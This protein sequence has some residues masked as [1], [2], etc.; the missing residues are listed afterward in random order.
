MIP[1]KEKETK[2]LGQ[3]RD[4]YHLVLFPFSFYG[5]TR[6]LIE[7]YLKGKNL[8]S[9]VYLT[10]HTGKIVDFK[11]ELF[12]TLKAPVPP[13][14]FTLRS[15][16]KKL[17]EEH[18]SKRLI[19]SVEKYIRLVRLVSRCSPDIPGFSLLG[20]VTA[21]SQFIREIKVHSSVSQLDWIFSRVAS[22]PWK[23][24]ESKKKAMVAVKIFSAYQNE[25]EKENL[26]DQ[27]DIYRQATSYVKHLPYSHF[28]VEGVYEI[29][30]YQ[31][32]FLAALFTHIPSGVF[33]FVDGTSA[34]I[35]VRTLILSQTLKT[36]QQFRTWQE[37]SFSSPP[38]N[39][40][41]ICWQFP[42]VE[43]EVKGI[44][45]MIK[46]FLE[47]H[48]ESRLED[49]LV[50]FPEMLA[51]RA[52]VKRLF[53]RYQIPCE[54]VPG[55]ALTEEPAINSLLDVFHFL[56]TWS[57]E[58]LMSIL[59]SPFFHRFQHQQVEIFST[60]SRL[61]HESSGYFRDDFLKEE[62]IY[63]DLLRK[64]LQ[65]M[66]GAERKSLTQWCRYLENIISRLKW[67]SGDE[68]VNFL[69]QEF[70]LQ[71][72]SS[73]RLTRKEFVNFFRHALSLMEVEQGRG[74][75]VKVSGVLETAGLERHLCII[76]GATDQS[77]PL[78]ASK[79]DI[80]LPDRLKEELKLDTYPL[81]LARERLDLH[82]L[83]QQNRKVCFTYSSLSQGR[84]Q[85]K[86]IL[87]G[88]YREK[89]WPGQPFRFSSDPI[90]TPD[91]SWEE[92]G[93][94][95]SRD[96]RW[97]IS[98]NGLEQILCCPYR[99]FLEKIA[100][101]IPYRAPVVEEVPRFWGEIV[102]KVLEE[103]GQKQLGRIIEAGAVTEYSEYFRTRLNQ[104]LISAGEEKK[105]C[106]P[107][108]RTI[109]QERLP[110]VV[111][112]LGEILLQ[113]VGRKVVSVEEKFE[114]KTNSWI[115]TGKTDRIEQI[116]DEELEVIDFKTGTTKP[117][118]YTEHDF[119]TRHHLQLP[120]YIWALEKLTNKVYHGSIWQL[121]YQED[122]GRGEKKYPRKGMLSYLERMED[123]LEDIAS[124]LKSG[125]FPAG[126]DNRQICQMCSHF[127]YCRHAS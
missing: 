39:E 7:T 64:L 46:Q 81:R 10:A 99:F 121:S 122:S 44:I 57:W 54:I 103:I 95:L 69:F 117:P 14:T 75:G 25:L 67:N 11:T 56:E 76:G 42:S 74:Y 115:I 127:A 17:V 3:N 119:T 84:P 60:C 111:S 77:L 107:L 59:T 28:L 101:L 26:L 37:K 52:L 113:H 86:S 36:L 73:H 93:K 32:E 16:A 109:L 47:E 65:P 68:Q 87:I 2:L 116:S 66:S 53:A 80:F 24:E 34:P 50:A 110:L 90:F 91:F 124:Q 105:V 102:H 61:R 125:Q 72:K 23:Y 70:L 123:Y 88:S 98:V 31:Q 15:L 30:A 49:C 71:V 29:P 38:S 19:S 55:V 9:L 33:A 94:F 20:M 114:V 58:A 40:N 89:V 48:P 83:T 35:D 118:S 108:I 45:T 92:I 106:S 126:P 104:L 1:H 78:S 8:Q 112:K 12:L 5:K 27:E 63:F 41:I 4:D 21:I 13:D 85:M 62:G 6:Y 18:S 79:M 22:Y 43:E 97:Q 82:R 51:Y 120:L 100:N 96:G